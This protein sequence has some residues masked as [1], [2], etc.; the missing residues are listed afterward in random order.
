MTGLLMQ[1]E[2]LPLC[3]TLCV[4]NQD[5]SYAAT[6]WLS[7]QQACQLHD[8][9]A[10]SQAAASQALSLQ[11]MQQS[12]YEKVAQE[13]FAVSNASSSS[14]EVPKWV[15]SVLKKYPARQRRRGRKTK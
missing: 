4:L 3:A 2:L 7:P 15:T 5:G 9:T 10:L 6:P 1:V 13:P 8:Q 14:E 11:T 12:V